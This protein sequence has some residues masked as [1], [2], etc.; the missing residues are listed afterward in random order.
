MKTTLNFQGLEVTFSGHALDVLRISFALAKVQS[1]I[2]QHVV[3]MIKVVQTSQDLVEWVT[4]G[5]VGLEFTKVVDVLSCLLDGVEYEEY[6]GLIQHDFEIQIKITGEETHEIFNLKITGEEA[7]EVLE[8]KV[9]LYNSCDA[10]LQDFR[11]MLEGLSEIS[12]FVEEI[13]QVKRR[14]V[15]K[16]NFSWNRIKHTDGTVWYRYRVTDG[17]LDVTFV[18]NEGEFSV[19]KDNVPC[20]YRY[21]EVPEL[22]VEEL[23]RSNPLQ[24]VK[25]NLEI[26]ETKELIYNE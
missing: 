1:F 25:K 18:N 14:E 15:A 21:V 24:C 19:R 26:K 9:A 12:P 23:K 6:F 4:G 17:T 3:N 10:I 11:K 13:F 16:R 8:E 22:I 5:C 20:F 2:G 7:H